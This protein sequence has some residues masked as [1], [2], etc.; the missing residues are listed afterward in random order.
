MDNDE[1][2]KQSNCLNQINNYINTKDKL[3]GNID[4]LIYLQKKLETVNWLSNQ[5][6]F[7]LD[8]NPSFLMNIEYNDIIPKY[9]REYLIP[10]SDLTGYDHLSVCM[11]L[12]NIISSAI[13]GK[14]IVK[15][16][17]GWT[18]PVCLYTLLI[19]PSGSKKVL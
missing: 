18:E 2:K 17:Q 14:F 19:A 10:I 4:D 11:G 15:V 6:I 9:L 1:L 5:Q 3:L 8:S 13:N 12:L 7:K 16:N